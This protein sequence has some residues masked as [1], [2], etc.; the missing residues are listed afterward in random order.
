MW[1]RIVWY[2]FTDVSEDPIA[3]IISQWWLDNYDSAVIMV[4]SGFSKTSLRTYP[5]TPPHIIQSFSKLYSYFCVRA[6]ALTYI[7][8]CRLLFIGLS[9]KSQTVVKDPPTLLVSI[10]VTV[11]PRIQTVAG[12]YPSC[13]DL[14]CQLFAALASGFLSQCLKKRHKN[15][16]RYSS[17]L[18]IIIQP[19]T[20]GSSIGFTVDSYLYNKR[21][22]ITYGLQVSQRLRVPYKCLKRTTF[23]SV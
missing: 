16:S 12:S 17:L 3:S 11:T 13:P 19:H 2:I 20:F 1:R 22:P 15:I 8:V 7:C 6:S 23:L 18:F 4:T 14:D 10:T 21:I 5:T 9:L